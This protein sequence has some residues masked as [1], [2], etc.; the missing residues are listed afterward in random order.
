MSPDLALA[1]PPVP[2][3]FRGP[4]LAALGVVLATL[5][6]FVI[7][8]VTAPINSGAIA[9]GEVIP[10]GKSRTVQHLEGGI[11]RA[12]HVRDGERVANG[13]PL[14]DLDQAEAR[15]AL[16][17]AATD[18]AAQAALLARLSAE[19]DGA[20]LPPL[21]TSNDSVRNQARLFDARRAALAKDIAGLQKR[22]ADARTELKGWS[23]KAGHLSALSDFAVEESRINQD[24]YDKNFIAKPRLLQLESRK[25]ETAAAMAENDAEMARARQK[26]TEAESAIAKLQGDWLNNLLEELRRAQEAHAA[27]AERSKVARERLARTRITAPQEGTVQGLKYTTL[28]GV[29][30]P[31]GAILDIT[32]ASDRLVVEAQLAPDF[33]DVVQVG[34]PARV[35]LT[36]YKVRRHFTI[37][38][39]VTQVSADTF[40]EERT[41]RSYY[42]VRVEV[43]DEE[44]KLAGG[45]TLAPGMQAQVE[46][47]TGE[48]SALRY[49]IDPV[50]DSV[51]RSMKEK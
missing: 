23:G 22:I 16:A 9:P 1:A 45:M 37:K 43:P 21:H 41:G 31:G 29:V 28:G 12:I 46:I 47:V 18:E 6:I 51:N 49:L 40:K 25:S 27:A 39:Q 17:I 7:W 5:A 36:A 32:P 3:S 48:R 13:A 34:L 42:K 50:V 11:I 38:G 2:T 30:P 35:R 19:R 4:A 15:A 20:R 33:I 14:L 24:L 8:G 10:A 26:I 44:L